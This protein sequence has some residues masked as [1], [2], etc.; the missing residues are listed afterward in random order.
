MSIQQKTPGPFRASG[1]TTFLAFVLL[2]ILAFSIGWQ[3]SQTRSEGQKKSQTEFVDDSNV[4][5]T[6]S[7]VQNI[8]ISLLRDAIDIIRE[9]YIE[10]DQI[11]PDAIKYG[12]VRGVVWSL[13]D[14]YSQFM[15]PEESSEFEDE[16]G[17]DLQG[18][19]AELT[20][21]E[22]V[23][24]VISPL[25]DS[26]AKKAGLLPEDIILEV[27]G[28]LA[29]G[30]DFLNVVK[31][32]RGEKGSTVN[33]TVY[34]PESG[35]KLDLAIVR[36]EIRIET[37]T[38]TMNEEIAIIEVSQ[39]GTNTEQEFGKALS[40]AL[41]QN[42][43]GIILD[44][45]YNS[46]GFLDTAVEM[47]SAF[48]KSGKVVIQKG[49]PPETE[50]KFASGNVKTDLPLVVLQNGGSASAS[51]IVSGALQDMERAIVIGEKS[52]G[53]G[54]VQELIPMQ[55]GAHL[56]LTIA[57]WLTPGGRDIGKVGIEPD[58]T[59]PRTSEDI[60]AD[61]D[62]QLDV[63][64]RYLRGESL[65]TLHEEYDSFAEKLKNGELEEKPEEKEE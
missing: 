35:E 26:P 23:I 65:E 62:P 3:A 47:V 20:V 7:S 33:I 63:A 16:L 28:E 49:R 5:I 9:K 40:E 8:D 61:K 24:V 6:E 4:A 27:D 18:I 15:S 32:I 11:D 42:P 43:K 12:L 59:V 37:V 64:L 45:R 55:N 34:R 13:E 30:G 25:K 19:G 38:L 14:P 36:D 41:V 21:K 58:I 46:G 51:E 17:G 56:R 60:A 29:D 39:F 57:K 22:G 2:P 52:F 54:T 48:V 31:R 53:K 1:P 10:P 50:S 44:L